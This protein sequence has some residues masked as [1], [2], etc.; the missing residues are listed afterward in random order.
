MGSSGRNQG[1][2]K[3]EWRV[4]GLVISPDLRAL[5]RAGIRP[6]WSKYGCALLGSTGVDVVLDY[7][8]ESFLRGAR[9]SLWQ[10][11]MSPEVFYCDTT[12]RIRYWKLL[13]G[14]GSLPR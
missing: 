1:A 7:H 13:N 14:Y 8:S 11:S 5:P 4:E 2:P 3:T 6:C 9:E 12:C 10:R